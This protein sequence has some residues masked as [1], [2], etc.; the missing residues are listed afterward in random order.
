MPRAERVYP[1]IRLAFA[2]EDA[3]TS[4]RALRI[5]VPCGTMLP[6]MLTYGLLGSFTSVDVK[7]GGSPGF[8]SKK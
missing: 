4:K 6:D 3:K 7:R 2:F 8:V 5:C 1:A